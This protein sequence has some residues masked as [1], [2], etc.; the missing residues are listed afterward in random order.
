MIQFR[1]RTHRDPIQ[2]LWQVA[3]PDDGSFAGRP[4]EGVLKAGLRSDGWVPEVR[5]LEPGLY[6]QA[7]LQ[8]GVNE[9]LTDYDEVD[10]AEAGLAETSHIGLTASDFDL[11]SVCSSIRQ[12]FSRMVVIKDDRNSSSARTDAGFRSDERLYPALRDTILKLIMS[13]NTGAQTPRYHS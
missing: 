3:R 10:L 4:L 11:D 13:L 2:K 5:G 1:C 6:C 9:A 8:E 7:C 12:H